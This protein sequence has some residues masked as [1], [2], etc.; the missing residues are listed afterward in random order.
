[1]MLALKIVGAAI[2]IASAMA[3]AEK[4]PP[5]KLIDSQSG[6]DTL[7]EEASV[8]LFRDTKVW[9]EMWLRHK[10][11]G[12]QIST[13]A[14]NM[15]VEP[16]PQLDFKKQMVLALFTGE[17]QGSGSSYRVVDIHSAGNR[18]VVRLK[19]ESFVDGPVSPNVKVGGRGFTFFLLSRTSKEV[20]VEV[21]DGKKWRP[22]GQ[23]PELKAAKTTATKG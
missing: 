8:E 10:G 16:V 2:A 1:M 19:P 5:V 9:E 18:V 6:L 15:Y 13:Q 14:L 12:N 7:V 22:V 20:M 3:N 17:N 21:T 4:E 23:F 11:R